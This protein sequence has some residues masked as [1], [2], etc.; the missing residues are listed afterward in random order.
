LLLAT[1]SPVTTTLPLAAPP[2]TFTLLL[3]TLQLLAAC[4]A[5]LPRSVTVLLPWLDP[6]LPPVIFIAVPIAPDAGSSCQC[7]PLHTHKGRSSRSS[8]L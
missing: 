1:P 5:A 6:K 7:S 2:G 3:L 4:A 8:S